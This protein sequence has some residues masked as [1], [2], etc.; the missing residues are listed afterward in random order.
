MGDFCIIKNW[1]P[2][3][4]KAPVEK[5]N[6]EFVAMRFIAQQIKQLNILHYF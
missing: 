1:C 6:N 2:T 4:K 5:K 3:N